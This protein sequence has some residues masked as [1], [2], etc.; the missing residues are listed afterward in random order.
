M[1]V[2]EWVDTYG[3]HHWRIVWSSYRKL[4][5]V[6]FDLISPLWQLRHLGT[7]YGD[8]REGTVFSW[9]YIYNA[10][11]YLA[12][13]RF[14]HCVYIY[15]IYIYISK[16]EKSISFEPNELM[17]GQ[18]VQQTRALKSKNRKKT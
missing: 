4:A 1:S 3:I 2:A 9:L 11:A 10:N 14:E 5:W 7:W 16:I 18:I 6:G 12:S 17:N 13:M 8:N 15:Y